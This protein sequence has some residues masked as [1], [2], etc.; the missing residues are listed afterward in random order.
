MALKIY[1]NGNLA[2]TPEPLNL[3]QRLVIVNNLTTNHGWRI[4]SRDTNE[5]HLR[6]GRLT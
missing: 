5:I 2:P 3:R 1:L 6:K 4:V